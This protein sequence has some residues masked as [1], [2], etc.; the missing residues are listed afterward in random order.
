MKFDC[1]ELA[2]EYMLGSNMLCNDIVLVE[3]QW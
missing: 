3:M 1:P 2:E